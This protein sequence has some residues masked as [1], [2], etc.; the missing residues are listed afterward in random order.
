MD[1]DDE[2]FEDADTADGSDAPDFRAIVQRSGA[3]RLVYW[4]P[5]LQSTGPAY[6]LMTARDR[7]G[8]AIADLRVVRDDEGA[9]SEVIVE[10]HS[11]GT[12]IHRAAIVDWA[13]A[14]GYAR[15]WFDGELV[16]LEPATG[17]VVTTRCTGCGQRFVD[18]RSGHFW[19]H[20]RCSGA[21]P[22]VCSL[23]G[24]DLPQWRPMTRAASGK[25]S[26]VPETQGHPANVGE[27]AH[28]R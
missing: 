25:A 22:L 21:F 19:H 16:D 15:V 17:G 12:D 23:C 3:V 8:V 14:V 2:T 11:G 20:V 18:G 6:T 24:S 13:H 27:R 26:R 10:F 4:G 1:F 7:A 5:W 9:A 28:R